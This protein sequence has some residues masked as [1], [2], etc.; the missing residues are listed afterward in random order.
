MRA[1]C[2]IIAE[3]VLDSSRELLVVVH[4]TIRAYLSVTQGG[5]YAGVMSPQFA[6]HDTYLKSTF[7]QCLG[8]PGL[9][10]WET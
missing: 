4:K 1:C 3:S 9:C 7:T 2:K 6:S 10:V 5:H 8:Q